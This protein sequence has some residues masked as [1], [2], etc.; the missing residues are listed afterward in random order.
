MAQLGYPQGDRSIFS[1]R[2]PRGD[3][4]LS[5]GV[6][7]GTGDRVKNA[8]GSVIV[9]VIVPQT[10][11]AG[12]V[13]PNH[14]VWMRK[15]GE[16]YASAS[17]G[18]GPQ[19]LLVGTGGK[20]SY[21]G[22]QPHKK[23]DTHYFYGI[24]VGGAKAV[25]STQSRDKMYRHD[26][27][28]RGV[29]R[30]PQHWLWT[31]DGTLTKEESV[32]KPY[33]YNSGIVVWHRKFRIPYCIDHFTWRNLQKDE[34]EKYE[35]LGQFYSHVTDFRANNSDATRSVKLHRDTVRNAL[36]VQGGKSVSYRMRRV[37]ARTFQVFLRT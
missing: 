13:Y 11:G 25:M 24:A 31:P 4:P 32:L 18:G 12:A 22:K 3:A 6:V 1:V 5:T 26:V 16:A 10:T 9:P 14:P 15:D 34:R 29:Y 35:C 36:V 20:P 28:V 2:M 27:C 23:Y 21:D 17:D 33:M 30:A 37:D 19:N 7:P 8:N